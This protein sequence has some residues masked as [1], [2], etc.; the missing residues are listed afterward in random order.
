MEH[1]PVRKA[2]GWDPWDP[3]RGCLHTVQGGVT[4]S[5]LVTGLSAQP[6]S[7]PLC[8]SSNAEVS[9]ASREGGGEGKKGDSWHPGKEE[10]ELNSVVYILL[11]GHQPQTRGGSPAAVSKGESLGEAGSSLLL[12]PGKQR[13]T[14]KEQDRKM[15]PGN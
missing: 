5:I 11:H 7:K 12:L 2:P 14:G 6:L 15:E 4:A 9:P 1:H 10:K 13:F 8:S 3:A